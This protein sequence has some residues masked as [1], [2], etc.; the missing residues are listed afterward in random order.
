MNLGLKH[1]KLA[2]LRND[3]KLELRKG[4]IVQTEIEQ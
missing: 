1:D 4:K 3:K 2:K